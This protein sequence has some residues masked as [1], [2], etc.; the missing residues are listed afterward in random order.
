M[1]LMHDTGLLISTRSLSHVVS[2][3]MV[4][5]GKNFWI[6]KL[7]LGYSIYIYSCWVLPT[8]TAQIQWDPRQLDR[9]SSTLKSSWQYDLICMQYQYCCSINAFTFVLVWLILCSHVSG[10]PRTGIQSTSHPHLHS[11]IITMTNT[12]PPTP[13]GASLLLAWAPLLMSPW[14]IFPFSQFF[15]I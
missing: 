9:L 10:L 11:H 8:P 1:L 2:N 4:K 7:Q 3:E 6:C 13:W 12:G 5:L 14:V 15:L